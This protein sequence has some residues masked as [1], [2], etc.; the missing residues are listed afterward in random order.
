MTC[1]GWTYWIS[2]W[3]H[4]NVIVPLLV[5]SIRHVT[6][7]LCIQIVI[8]DQIK[9]WARHLLPWRSLFQVQHVWQQHTVLCQAAVNTL[10]HNSQPQPQQRQQHNTT[11]YTCTAPAQQQLAGERTPRHTKTASTNRHVSLF[12]LHRFRH[13]CRP[14]AKILVITIGIVGIV[15]LVAISI[16]VV[17]GGVSCS[18]WCS[19]K[20]KRRAC[21]VV[22]RLHHFF[23]WIEASFLPPG[24]SLS[25]RQ[26][27]EGIFR[28]ISVRI[29]SPFRHFLCRI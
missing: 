4:V 12:R 13:L 14:M 3:N 16:V 27:S 25:P 5:L 23:E 24:Q 8:T 11:A 28:Q 1:H 21:G 10:V 2:C 26:N 18:W 22:V 29:P 19:A 9:L 15:G 17:L 7:K 20:R 6:G